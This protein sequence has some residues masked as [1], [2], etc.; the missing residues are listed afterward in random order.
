MT[1][2]Q[3]WRRRNLHGSELHTKTGI[4]PDKTGISNHGTK[5]GRNREQTGNHLLLHRSRFIH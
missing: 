3:L 4:Q 2:C 1:S 5:C